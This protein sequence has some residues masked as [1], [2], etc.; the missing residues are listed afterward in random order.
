MTIARLSVRVD[1]AQNTVQLF[2]GLTPPYLA[3]GVETVLV[4]SGLCLPNASVED[5]GSP[6]DSVSVFFGRMRAEV[7]GG[8]IACYEFVIHHNNFHNNQS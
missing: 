2:Q 7:G 6:V 1:I 5:T 8:G 3:G 4:G